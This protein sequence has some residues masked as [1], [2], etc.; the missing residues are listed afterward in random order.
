MRATGL[1]RNVFEFS[2]ADHSVSCFHHRER[3]IV[4]R[5]LVRLRYPCRGCRFPVYPKQQ[6]GHPIWSEVLR[7]VAHGLA[8][9]YHEVRRSA[10]GS[11]SDR[12]LLPIAGGE[13]VGDCSIRNIA[14]R[15]SAIVYSECRQAGQNITATG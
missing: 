11:Q 5:T 3:K 12:H 2:I 8:W 7:A 10:L 15:I 13:R 14:L 1:G 6:Q 9:I 4:N